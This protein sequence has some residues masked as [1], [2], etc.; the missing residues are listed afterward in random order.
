[1]HSA[2]EPALQHIDYLLATLLPQPAPVT[3]YTEDPTSENVHTQLQQFT[4]KLT[5]LAPAHILLAHA[6]AINFGLW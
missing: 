6:M 5:A 3:F 2:T 1:M 4:T